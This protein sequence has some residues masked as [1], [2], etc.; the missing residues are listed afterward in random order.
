MKQLKRIMLTAAVLVLATTNA[1]AAGIWLYEM[2]Q[3][4]MGTATAGRAAM[5]RDASTAFSNPAGMTRLDRSQ[6]TAAGLLLDVNIEFDGQTT[7]N[8]WNNSNTETTGN[9]HNA[10]GFVPAGS[11]N[12]VQVVT[13]DLRLGL[14]V[15]SYF[16]LGGEF[17]NSWQGRY[18][19]QRLELMTMAINP[20]AAYKVNDWFSVGGGVTSLYSL[21]KTDMAINNRNHLNPNDPPQPDGQFKINSN[22]WGWGYNAGVMM[23][24]T[25]STRV[26]LTYRSKIDLKFDDS[27][28]VSGVTGPIGARIAEVLNNGMLGLE[29]TVPQAADLSCYQQVT[30]KLALMANLGWQDWSRF[31]SLEVDL[32]TAAGA[33]RSTTADMHFDDTWHAA[34]G[35]H[36]RIADPWLLML[37]FAYDSSP[38]KDQFRSI[39]L[40]LDRQYRY[41]TGVEY[42]WSKDVTVGFDYTFID[43]GKAR[44]NNNRGPF[45]GNIVGELSTDYMS[46]FGLNVNWKF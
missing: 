39:V 45:A 15:G 44:V 20:V 29:I 17:G 16:G 41:A 36:Y 26:G 7:W 4:D 5:A 28:A 21:L 40:P 1:R 10:G 30:D 27:P 38:V 31:G 14:T 18:Y 32:S 8:T 12:Y 2:G 25:K 19:A 11:F 42:T 23:E 3:A 9:Q 43:L 46:A 24:P 13:P 33:G 22:D 37:G 34:L 35:A 6:L